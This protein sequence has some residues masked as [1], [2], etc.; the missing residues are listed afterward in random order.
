MEYVTIPSWVEMF[1]GANKYLH[2]QTLPITYKHEYFIYFFGSNFC[3][4]EICQGKVL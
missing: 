1:M 3:V 2:Q 4:I